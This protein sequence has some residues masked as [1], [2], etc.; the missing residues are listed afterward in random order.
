MGHTVPISGYDALLKRNY[1]HAAFVP[2][3]LPTQLQLSPRTYKLVSEAERELGRLDAAATRLP[4]PA[5]LIRPTL[6]DDGRK[7]NRFDGEK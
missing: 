3:P 6:V 1:A 5:L 2:D 4:N 7:L